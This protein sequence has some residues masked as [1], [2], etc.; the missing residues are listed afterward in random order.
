[1]KTSFSD[2]PGPG[3]IDLNVQDLPHRSSELEWWY[4]NA[5]FITNCSQHFSLFAAFFRILRDEPRGE[6]SPYS[7][8]IT[9]GIIDPKNQK[10]LTNVLVDP[11]TPQDLLKELN[12]GLMSKDLKIRRALAE[13]FE[14]GHVLLPDQLL[15]RNAIIKLDCLDLD[16]DGNL[17]F[18]RADNSYELQLFDKHH[19]NGCNLIFTPQIPPVR[20]GIN[21]KGTE[22]EKFYYFIPRCD[23]KGEIILSH[24]AL[25]VKHG[26]G[27]YDHE[28]GR[29]GSIGNWAWNWLSVQFDN[30][31]ELILYDLINMDEEKTIEHR[32]ILIDPEG[33]QQ[34]YAEFQFEPTLHWT[35]TLTFNKYPVAWQLNLPEAQ[36]SLRI[37]A[38]LPNQECLT[39]IALKGF[40]EGRV[41]VVGTWNGQI[42]KGLGVFERTGFNNIESA[43]EFFKIIGNETKLCLNKMLPSSPSYKEAIELLASKQHPF[44]LE[45]VNID[46]MWKVIINPIKDILYRGGKA[47]R[48]YIILAIIDLLEKDSNLYRDL[49]TIPE[50]LHVGSLIIDDVQDHSEI[51]RGG[52]T[53]HKIYGE[54]LAINAGTIC[55]FLGLNSISKHNLSEVK[56][57]LFMKII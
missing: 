53:T 47:W 54:A 16:Y 29:K 30:N 28:F 39:I 11:L 2:W 35:N 4:V 49:L 27:W 34:N 10:Y 14:K 26:K 44:A 55:Y 51:R 9:W 52:P 37:K 33:K 13:I 18:K 21:A 36:L 15:Q 3:P 12:K 38:S 32:L 17:F 42:I 57:L 20:Y 46:E 6:E 25:P 43:E 1:M 56:K 48:S 8:Y 19:G 50:L 22:A 5:H 24:Q 31:W 45:G 23:L 41:E 40:W 7:H